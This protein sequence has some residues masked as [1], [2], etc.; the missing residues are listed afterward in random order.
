MKMGETS[1]Q[2]NL[3]QPESPDKLRLISALTGLRGLSQLYAD[4]KESHAAA[5][6]RLP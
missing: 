3:V 5:D 1:N 6:R 2:V 4:Y